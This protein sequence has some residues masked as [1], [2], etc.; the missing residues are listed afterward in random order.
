MSPSLD[1]RS[2]VTRTEQVVLTRGLGSLG[3]IR[4]LVHPS[5]STPERPGDAS[6]EAAP[7]RPPAGLPRL[8]WELVAAGDG[9]PDSV[10]DGDVHALVLA[11]DATAASRPD[12]LAT[13]RPWVVVLR[14]DRPDADDWERDLA[15]AKFTLTV[16]DGRS[17]YFVSADHDDLHEAF[18]G[19]DESAWDGLVDE[20]VRW[21]TAALGRWALATGADPGRQSRAERELVAMRETVS[22]R[23]TAPLRKVRSRMRP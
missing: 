21:R 10:D 9:G 17:R 23:V 2:L 12:L 16:F 7:E 20:V 13:T 3:T 6:A 22:W 19:V 4:L 1:P 8:V 11:G 18:A 15:D 5:A 14:T